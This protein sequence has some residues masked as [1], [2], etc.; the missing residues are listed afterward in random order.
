M[1]NIIQLCITVVFTIGAINI[2]GQ[3]TKVNLEVSSNL[4]SEIPTHDLK[5]DL[6]LQWYQQNNEIHEHNWK[7]VFRLKQKE[8][9]KTDKRCYMCIGAG[10]GAIG[11]ILIGFNYNNYYKEG[12]STE[13]VL[14]WTLIGTLIGGG[15]GLTIDIAKGI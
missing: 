15:L 11:G 5:S 8:E 7:K 14:G 6:G 2:N 3:Y 1:K 13:T 12:D 4:F 10:I 9:E